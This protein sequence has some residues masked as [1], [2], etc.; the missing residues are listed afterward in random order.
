MKKQIFRTTSLTIFALTLSCLLMSA[1][2]KLPIGPTGPDPVPP[3]L[4]GTYLSFA[5]FRALFTGPADFSIPAGTKKIRGVVI[6]NSANEANGNNRLQD[7]SGAGIYFYSAFGS[8]D[9]PMGTVLEIDAAGSG[10]LTLYK[11]DLE[12]KN[13]PEA[14]VKIIGGTINITPRVAKIA[15]I[16][17]NRD[18]WASSLVKIENVTAITQTYSNSTGNTYDITDATGTVSMFVRNA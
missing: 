13:V 8:P 3:P 7:E 9:Y 10:V 16:I 18:T 1:C 17:A 14:N 5:D 12:L 6:S 2:N 4:P 15:D 11:G